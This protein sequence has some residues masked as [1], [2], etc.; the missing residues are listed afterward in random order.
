MPIQIPYCYLFS[1]LLL[2]RTIATTISTIKI[3][4]IMKKVPSFLTVPFGRIKRIT[5]KNSGTISTNR[6]TRIFGVFYR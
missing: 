4:S 6:S 3:V 1:R 5:N 2:L